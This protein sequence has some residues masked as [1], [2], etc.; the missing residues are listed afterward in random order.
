MGRGAGDGSE[1]NE[2]IR[3][4]GE[5]LVKICLPTAHFLLCSPVPNRPLMDRSVALGFGALWV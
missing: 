2:S 4:D 1:G 3:R 5:R